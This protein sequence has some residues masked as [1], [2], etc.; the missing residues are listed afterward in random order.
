MDIID[1][2][3]VR[4]GFTQLLVN[5]SEDIESE[6]SVMLCV[7][8]SGVIEKNVTVRVA[9]ESSNNLLRAATASE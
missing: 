4:V 7:Q 6:R 8:L 2:D 3:S 1:D 5:V 9:T